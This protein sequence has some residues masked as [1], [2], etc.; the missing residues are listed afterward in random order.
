L[1]FFV[2]Q[3]FVLKDDPFTKISLYLPIDK[4][5]PD[6]KGM[7]LKGVVGSV[8]TVNGMCKIE[9]DDL[10]NVVNFTLEDYEYSDPELMQKDITIKLR[11]GWTATRSLEGMP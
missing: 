2:K 5:E 4:V 1:K 7:D 8:K 6:E 11:F 3:R 9:Q 10:L